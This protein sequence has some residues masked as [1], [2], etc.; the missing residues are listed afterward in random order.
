LILLDSHRAAHCDHRTAADEDVAQEIVQETRV[1]PEEFLGCPMLTRGLQKRMSKLIRALA[2]ELP[3]TRNEGGH[4]HGTY[5]I[6]K[7]ARRASGQAWFAMARGWVSAAGHVL[8]G[9]VAGG[10]YIAL[11]RR[12]ASA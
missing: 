9:L 12:R 5:R 7:S 2:I 1:G 4:C 3:I 6:R 10:A 8:F 11:R